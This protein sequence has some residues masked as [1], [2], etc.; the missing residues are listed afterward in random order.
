MQ[1]FFT[2]ANQALY[3]E[4]SDYAAVL[5]TIVSALP[6]ARALCEQAVREVRLVQ[7][8]IAFGD[9]PQIIE[10]TRIALH[11]GNLWAVRDDLPA[12]TSGFSSEIEE[13]IRACEL[14]ETAQRVVASREQDA[15]SAELRVC[16]TNILTHLREQQHLLEECNQLLEPFRTS[17]DLTRKRL[18]LLIAAAE[19]RLPNT[20]ARQAAVQTYHEAAAL[21]GEWESG[22]ALDERGIGVLE[23]CLAII[24]H[25]GDTFGMI[26]VPA[27]SQP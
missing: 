20:P 27:H 11:L 14:A 5:R 3:Q 18:A 25:S 22:I 21:L 9:G 23:R 13:S 7:A 24:S 10:L 4:L 8:L 19:A 26:A 17:P 2:R 1:H 12:R 6:Q 16:F 15:L